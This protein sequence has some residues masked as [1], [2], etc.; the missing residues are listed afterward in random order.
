MQEDARWQ[1]GRYLQYTDRSKKSEQ[2]GTSVRQD[3]DYKWS[4]D[5][6]GQVCHSC[7]INGWSWVH[8]PLPITFS[9]P[10][11]RLMGFLSRA[12]WTGINGSPSGSPHNQETRLSHP[13]RLSPEKLFI[14]SLLRAYCKRESPRFVKIFPH[15]ASNG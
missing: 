5:W 9:S 10:R 12:R 11:D 3:Y 13:V 1:A 6:I 8:F 2:R 15:S 4:R 14:A 7:L